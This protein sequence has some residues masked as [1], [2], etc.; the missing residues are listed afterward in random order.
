MNLKITDGFVKSVNHMYLN[1]GLNASITMVVSSS[2]E[3]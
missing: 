2:E 3:D 1:K